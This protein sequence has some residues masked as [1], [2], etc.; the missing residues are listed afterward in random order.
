MG[1][2]WWCCCGWPKPIRDIYDAAEMK[3]E[4]IGSNKSR[5]HYG[6][7]HIVWGDENFEQHHIQSCLD[8]F[9]RWCDNFTEQEKDIVRQSLL[10]MLAI[11]DEYKHEPAGYDDEHPENYPPPEHWQC[12][13]R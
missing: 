10:D 7:A 3:L 2:C 13:R 4:T 9:D 6:P 5:L 12:E 11:P 1:A 8:D